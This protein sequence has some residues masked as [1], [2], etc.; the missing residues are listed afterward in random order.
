MGAD[1][2]IV[3]IDNVSLIKKYVP[4]DT[5]YYP[6]YES[7]FDGTSNVQSLTFPTSAESWAGFTNT[8]KNIYPLSFTNG[9]EITFKASA[10]TPATL[11]FGLSK[12]VLIPHLSFI[13]LTL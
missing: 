12:P 4:Q 1:T 13:L 10:A 6:L 9:G 3:V 2:G 8:N 11:K 7:A 5:L